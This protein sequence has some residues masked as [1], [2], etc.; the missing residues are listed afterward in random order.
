VT[1]AEFRAWLERRGL[2]YSQAA[3]LLAAHNTEVMRWAKGERKVPRKIAKI[4]EL[5]NEQE[6]IQELAREWLATAHEMMEPSDDAPAVQVVDTLVECA[7]DMLDL[8]AE[9]TP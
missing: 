5:R 8:L 9:M 7:N 1:A 3:P 2:N 6:R 4:V